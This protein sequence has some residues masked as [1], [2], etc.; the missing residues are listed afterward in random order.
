LDSVNA[1]TL[2]ALAISWMGKDPAIKVGAA[3][4][5]V[6]KASTAEPATMRVKISFM[7]GSLWIGGWPSVV[8]LQQ[9]SPRRSHAAKGIRRVLSEPFNVGKMQL[10]SMYE[11]LALIGR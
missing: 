9:F 11:R 10:I 1:L 6:G 4:A 3:S 7:L 8:L 5:I 2:V